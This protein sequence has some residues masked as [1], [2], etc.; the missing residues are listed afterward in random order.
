MVEQQVPL[1]V[2]FLFQFLLRLGM[3]VHL[4]FPFRRFHFFHRR[5]MVK[6]Y[7][8]SLLFMQAI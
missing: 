6:K 2:G 8:S 1:V 7:S 3:L 5:C 4:A